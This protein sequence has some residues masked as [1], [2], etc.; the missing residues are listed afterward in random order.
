MTVLLDCSDDMLIE[1]EDNEQDRIWQQIQ[2]AYYQPA[3]RW[4]A[5]INQLCLCGV[6]PLLLDQ[7]AFS[8]EN[9]DTLEMNGIPGVAVRLDAD[10]FVLIPSEAID[11]SELRVPQEWVDI[12]NWIGDYYL[13]VQ[14]NSEQ[15][16]AK[17]WGYTTHQALKQQGHYD[18]SDRTYSL[19]GDEL[20]TNMTSL[21][22]ARELGLDSPTPVAVKPIE[23]LP[24]AQVDALI[25]RLASPRV[26]MPRLEIP[27]DLWKALLANDEWRSRL[28][29]ALNVAPVP[30][31]EIADNTT[32]LSQWFDPLL[33]CGWIE[34]GWQTLET[35]L[36]SSSEWATVFRGTTSTDSVAPEISMG[37]RLTFEIEGDSIPLL[38]LMRAV[39]EADG[40]VLIQVQLRPDNNGEQT[41]ETLPEGIELGLLSPSGDV[42]QSLQGRSFDA[43]IQLKRFRLPA[44]T[45]FSLR[46][47]LGDE[48]VTEI[49]TT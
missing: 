14:I 23:P 11:Q 15:G 35:L 6:I 18:D 40:R 31:N 27:F 28:N 32:R 33:S 47:Q 29:D 16:W 43:F 34:Q 38:L 5:Y 41:A 21:M 26:L 37:K 48:A 7:D 42:I 44:N 10:Q 1:F 20:M 17:L 19:G 8:P 36:P 24:L 22:V 46:M 3:P 2:D 4:Q 39:N 13:A 45:Q 30:T 12:P 9:Y 25:Q 49:F